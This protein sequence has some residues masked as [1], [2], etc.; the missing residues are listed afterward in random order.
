MSRTVTRLFRCG[1]NLRGAP[2]G[3]S[4]CKDSKMTSFFMHPLFHSS[5]YSRPEMTTKGLDRLD[6]DWKTF[7]NIYTMMSKTPY[8][9]L[10]QIRNN[11]I[12]SLLSISYCLLSFSFI[13][14][15][16]FVGFVEIWILKESWDF[17]TFPC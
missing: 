14:W 12:L 9:T 15:S 10:T 8:I 17:F 11:I 3:C 2:P 16:L 1:N 5:T 7:G 13:V 6:K 4:A